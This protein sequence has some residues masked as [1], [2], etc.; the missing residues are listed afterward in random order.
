MAYYTHVDVSKCRSEHFH[1]SEAIE[2]NA[3]AGARAVEVTGQS[4]A[5][6]E[7]KDRGRR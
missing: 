2:C 1:I 4:E 7:R 6:Q 3:G 5:G